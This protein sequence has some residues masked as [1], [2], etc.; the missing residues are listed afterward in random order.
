MNRYAFD[1]VNARWRVRGGPNLVP[2]RQ[3]MYVSLPRAFSYGIFSCAFESEDAMK[4][5]KPKIVEI[6]I[7]MEI[8]DYFPA[9]L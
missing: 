5:S 1:R 7:G 6:C 2:Q 9:E 4:W 8:N 3:I